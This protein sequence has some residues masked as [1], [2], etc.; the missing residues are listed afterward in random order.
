VETGGDSFVVKT[1]GLKTAKDREVKVD[2]VVAGLGIQ[3]NVEL[4]QAAG[5]KVENGIVV[6]EFL[7]ASH[8]DIYAAGDVAAFYNRSLDKRIR[9]EHEDNAN[10]MGRL[11][12]RNMAGELQPYDYLPG[13]YSDLF[14]LGYEAVGE[15]SAKHEIVTDWKKIQPRRSD[16][17]FGEQSGSR[18]APMEC[19]GTSRRG[20]VSDCR[21]W[22]FSGKKPQRTPARGCKIGGERERLND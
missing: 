9:V 18:R 2:G 12:G 15:L 17:L 20:P 1:R 8:P 14:E 11:A 16:L 19:L 7:R 22:A 4:A 13:F 5:L 6:D 21:R 3:P 10:T